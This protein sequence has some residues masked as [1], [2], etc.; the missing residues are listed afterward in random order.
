[1][2][3]MISR[4]SECTE[5]EKLQSMFSLLYFSPHAHVLMVYIYHVFDEQLRMLLDETFFHPSHFRPLCTTPPLRRLYSY[6]SID[7]NFC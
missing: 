1:M 4:I 5:Y 7:D 6:C 3:K 2:L